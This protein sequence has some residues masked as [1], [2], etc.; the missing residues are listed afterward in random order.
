MKVIIHYI[1]N[2]NL[3]VSRLFA[4]GGMPSSHSALVVSLATLVGLLE[5]M[6]STTFAIAAGLAMV[7]MHDAMTV[8]RSVGQQASSLNNLHEIFNQMSVQMTDLIESKNEN[9]NIKLEKIKV[10]LGHSPLEV[11]VGGL[12][13]MLT[14]YLGYLLFLS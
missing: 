2:K 3:D 6:N 8:R 9:I 13:G 7:V 10:L 4:T 1:T 11:L 14:G 5:G 12:W